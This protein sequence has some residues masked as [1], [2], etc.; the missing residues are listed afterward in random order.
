MP[1]D[2]GFNALILFFNHID[3]RV[4]L[5][6]IVVEGVVL[7]LSLD[8]GGDNLFEVTDTSLLFDLLEG[9]LDDVNI[10]DVHVHKVLL[11]FVV[12]GPFLESQLEELD[13]VRELTN[14]SCL[15]ISGSNSN[16]GLGFFHFGIILDLKLLLK[17]LDFSLEIEF[18]SFVLGFQSEDLV[19]GFL[20]NS[21][22][23][24]GGLV[25]LLCSLVGNLNVFAI[26]VVNSDLVSH[27]LSHYINLV[28]QSLVLSLKSVVFDET[29]IELV[30]HGLDLVSISSDLSG[31]WSN[32]FEVIFLLDKLLLGLSELIFEDHEALL[33]MLEFLGETVSFSLESE[34]LTFI[35]GTWTHS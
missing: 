12:I 21:L 15:S 33:L 6:H 5:I 18:L 14:G 7:F 26:T 17:V 9:I 35:H 11:L 23:L 13:W 27:L 30:L 8:E 3:F 32:N 25:E 2:F 20:G 31:G 28:S 4:K 22:S 10:T 34:C 1:F 16:F 29:L 19:I 24:I